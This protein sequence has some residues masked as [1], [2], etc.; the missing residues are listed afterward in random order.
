MFCVGSAAWAESVPP[1]GIA[2]GDCAIFREGGDGRILRTP[3]FWL[4]GT[5]AGVARE[6][7]LAALCP[8]IGK[9]LAAYTRADYAQVAAASPCVQSDT[10]VR[11]VGVTR[12][13]LRVDD[14]ETPWAT[15]HGTTGWLFRGY[16]LAQS[17]QKGVVIDMDANWLERCE[18][19]S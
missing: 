8:Q 11:E 4:K 17:L 3:V 16:F 18:P 19:R 13:Q 7:R 14:W 10:E 6:R 15:Q 1:A 5:V 12:I 2:L 9:P